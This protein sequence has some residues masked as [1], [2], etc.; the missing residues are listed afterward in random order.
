MDV[1][2]FVVVFLVV[3]CVSFWVTDFVVYRSKM[4][5]YKVTGDGVISQKSSD[6]PL[7]KMC[8]PHKFYEGVK[9]HEQNTLG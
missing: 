3:F 5:K 6:I 9:A 2:V 7:K 1:A 8:E 4:P